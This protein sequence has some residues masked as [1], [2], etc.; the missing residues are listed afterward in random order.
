MR[1]PNNGK[2]IRY[3]EQRGTS[4][5]KIYSYGKVF[6]HTNEFL[7]KFY[8]LDVYNCSRHSNNHFSKEINIANYS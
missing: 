6:P 3:S 7:F 5:S 8:H 2:V 1:L 4:R